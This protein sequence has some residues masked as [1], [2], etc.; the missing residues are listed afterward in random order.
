MFTVLITS[1]I[2]GRERNGNWVI[3][4]LLKKVL[5]ENSDMLRFFRNRVRLIWIPYICASGDYENADGIN[6]N[7]DFPTTKA[8]TCQSN[9]ATYIKSVIDNYGSELD[10][11]IDAHTYNESAIYASSIPG[12]VF[13]DS[14]K[15][16]ERAVVTCQA[17]LDE[18]AR[19]YPSI[20][21]FTRQYFGA[22]NT[23]TTCTYYTQ[24]VYGVPA[25]TME[26][27]L[28]MS[29]SPTG[30]DE[31]TSATAYFYDMLTQTI[32]AMA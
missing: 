15:L 29:G 16:G 7:R 30:A 32:C 26:A 8:G 10:L 25:G 9:E 13:T 11:H 27:V 19:K 24:T 4:N 14:N 1:N 23:T 21:N 20:D 5:S 3:Y 6:I 17:V 28:T 18:Y 31:H 2:H 22:T 12:W